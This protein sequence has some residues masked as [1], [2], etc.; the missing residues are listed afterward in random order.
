MAG[1]VG[2]MKLDKLLRPE[3]RFMML[4]MPI[5]TGNKAIKTEHFEFH[6]GISVLEDIPGEGEEAVKYQSRY[7]RLSSER[8]VYLPD[9]S[10]D[11]RYYILTL[12][13]V[14]K[15]LRELKPPRLFLP[16]KILE[17]DLVVRISG[18]GCKN[19][20]RHDI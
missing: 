8:N 4:M 10:V 9:K 18:K 13:A 20:R 3:R 11:E 16:G 6:S 5:D 1:S 7:Y 12:F 2:D 19:N 15:E 17:I 14:A